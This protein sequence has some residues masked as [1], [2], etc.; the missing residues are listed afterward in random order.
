MALAGARGDG[1]PSARDLEH[2]RSRPRRSC[3]ERGV[4]VGDAPV[5]AA[6]ES[7]FDVWARVATSIVGSATAA[8]GESSTAR[9]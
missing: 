5:H 6:G 3:V 8:A 2:P 9:T 7:Q 1:R 4:R